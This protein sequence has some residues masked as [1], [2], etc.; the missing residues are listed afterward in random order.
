MRKRTKRKVYKLLDTMK[1]AKL[2][3]SVAS[4]EVL[5]Q[6]RMN[7]LIAIDDFFKGTATLTSWSSLKG[8]NN[9]AQTFA[10]EGIGIE[11]IEPCRALE[12]ALIEAAKRFEKTGKMGLSGTGLTAARE[13]QQLHDLQR[14]SIT[15][16]E[17]ERLVDKTENILKSKGRKVKE[18]V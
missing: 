10:D 4:K 7:E 13:V 17:Y 16:G 6:V 5:D 15:R 8:M 2:G 18:I 12:E 3:A 9:I 1:M 14:I 11:A